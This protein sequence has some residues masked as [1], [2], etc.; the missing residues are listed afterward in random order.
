MRIDFLKKNLSLPVDAIIQRF[1]EQENLEQVISN[2][3]VTNELIYTLTKNLKIISTS[4]TDSMRYLI[5]TFL[6]S[7]FLNKIKAFLIN[8][9]TN[10]KL[11]FEILI[12]EEK[13]TSLFECLSD[14]IE[15]FI[16]ISQYF[17][18]LQ[19]RFPIF[20]IK[21]LLNVIKSSYDQGDPIYEKTCSFKQKLKNLKSILNSNA[22]WSAEKSDLNQALKQGFFINSGVPINYKN[23][24]IEISRDELFDLKQKKLT[25]I[26]KKAHMKDGSDILTRCII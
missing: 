24:P 26:G 10:H 3:R 16:Q 9:T 1:L 8:I 19:V 25:L 17:Y 23:A 22:D 21:S 4:K 6:Q 14:L 15:F 18:S 5:N 12:N 13:Q 7:D 20:E 2:T 11:L